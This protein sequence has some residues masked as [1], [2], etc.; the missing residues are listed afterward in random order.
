MDQYFSFPFNVAERSQGFQLWQNGF[1]N[2]ELDKIIEIGESV[3]AEDAKVGGGSPEE[4]V[5]SAV[6]RSRVAWIKP[7]PENEWLFVSVCKIARDL[8]TQFYGFDLQG[9]MSLQYTT[10]TQEE[11]G[12]YDW[13]VDDMGVADGYSHRRKLSLTVQLSDPMAYEGGE[14]WVW[15][16]EKICAPKLRGLTA[17]FPASLL[18]RVTPVTA[19]KRQSLVAW[20]CG[21]DAR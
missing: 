6:R 17:A 3:T 15:G 19:G 4:S 21:P 13:H 2:A 5:D 20:V 8:N 14:L 16:R 1:T 18:H 7:T 9:L 12:H 10:Y 11:Q